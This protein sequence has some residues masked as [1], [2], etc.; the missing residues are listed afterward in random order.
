MKSAYDAAARMAS[1]AA[2]LTGD[3][4]HVLPP[5][6]A[7]TD[8]LRQPDPVALIAN[9]APGS[10]VIY[11][12]FGAADRLE[13]ARRAVTLANRKGVT[14]LVSSDPDLARRSGAHGIHWPEQHIAQAGRMRARGS[15]LIF[16]ASAHSVKALARARL[17]GIDATLV[18]TVFPSASPSAG[19]PMGP[20]ALAAWAQHSDMPIYALGGVN[21]RT[22]RRLESLQISGV[23]VVGALEVGAIRTA[24]PTQT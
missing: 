10:G 12:H 2:R 15:T 23:A 8:P 6:L 1:A 19:R 5:L 24:G 17:A 14:I 22:I 13:T 9:L 16:T 11:R 21:P 7:L 3:R 4:P 20:L 18:S